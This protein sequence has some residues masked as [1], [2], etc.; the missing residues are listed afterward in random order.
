MNTYTIIGII[1]ICFFAIIAIAIVGLLNTL[2]TQ[3]KEKN[4]LESMQPI[5]TV[6]YKED[7]I[8]NHLDYII[9]DALNIYTILNITSKSIYYINSKMEK[10]MIETI[11]NEIPE[12]LSPTLLTKLSYIYNTDYIGKFLGQHI[13]LVITQFVIDFNTQNGGNAK[14]E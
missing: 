2:I 14:A 5:M 11:Q 9:M 8:L 4:R 1:I 10:E 6:E 12:Q 3:L 7:E 13:Y